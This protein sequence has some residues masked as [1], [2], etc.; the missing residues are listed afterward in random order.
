MTGRETSKDREHRRATAGNSANGMI[1][2]NIV[3]PSSANGATED[4]TRPRILVVEDNADTRTL[5]NHLL[6]KTYHVH[7]VDDADQALELVSQVRF[8]A[9]LVDINL[10][11]GKS[12]EDVLH[13]IKSV[14]SYESTPVIAV[15]AYAMPGDRERF[16]AE[17][18]DEYVS[19]PFS[20][21]RLLEALE[22]VL[23]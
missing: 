7:I 20:K 15:T 13:A 12:G 9:V 19:K 11:K 5:V 10:G 23:T 14:P 22:G 8:D 6:R 3:R 2:S 18:F 16:F 17:G 4:A 1:F 21:Q